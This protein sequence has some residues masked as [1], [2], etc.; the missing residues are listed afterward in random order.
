[1]GKMILKKILN[2]LILIRKRLQAI[3]PEFRHKCDTGI[4]VLEKK[5]INQEDSQVTV[6]FELP[7]RD[8]CELSELP[9][10][11]EVENF[12]SRQ[13]R[14]SSQSLRTEGEG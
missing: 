12:L 1:M 11:I 3:C 10:W 4:H 6:S 8:W 2:E 14:T 7:G 13:E 5:Y 9:A